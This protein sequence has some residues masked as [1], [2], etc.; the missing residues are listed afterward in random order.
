VRRDRAVAALASSGIDVTPPAGGFYLMVPL[1]E[2]ADS[3]KA[4][5]N[6]ID[7]GVALSPGT[8]YSRTATNYL[9]ISLASSDHDLEHGIERVAAWL[10][11]SDNGLNP[12][13]AGELAY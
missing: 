2:G 8:A 13:P 7:H 5:F 11:Q 10:Q 1:A 3:K 9:R 6:L 12:V 4:A